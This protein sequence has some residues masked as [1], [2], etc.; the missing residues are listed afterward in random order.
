MTGLDLALLR[1]APSAVVAMDAEGRITALNPAAERLLSTTHDRAVGV[2]YTT[3]FGRSLSSRLIPLVARAGRSE[4]GTAHDVEATLPDGRRA[5]LRASAGPL[6][7]AG[8]VLTGIVFV[9]EDRT[10]AAAASAGQER[11]RDALRRYAG[12][13][14]AAGVDSHPSLIGVG[15]VRQVVSVLH[16]DVRGYTT[17]SEALPPEEVHALLMRFHGAA[18]AALRR[19]GATIDRYIGDAILAL[20]NAPTPDP[21]HARMALRGALAMRDATIEAGDEMRY[22][23]GVH[24]GDA[25]VGNLGSEQ[26]MH[27]TAIGD[28]VNIAARLQ[29]GAAGGEVVCSAATYRAAGEGI[30]ATPLGE[31]AVKGRKGT[32]EAYRVEGLDG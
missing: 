10:E 24:T 13:H 1:M 26:Y 14:I 12:D 2:P 22:G 32:V 25:V 18:V 4:P 11:L 7:D 9:A 8:G 16:S 5:R 29:G 20:W 19:E 6:T 17:V 30:R 27:Y 28:T 3:V 23:I 15:G 21:D 31:L